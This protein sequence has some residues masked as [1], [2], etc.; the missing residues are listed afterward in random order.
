M[1]GLDIHRW[2]P[3]PPILV[4]LV[5]GKHRVLLTPVLDHLAQVAG[6]QQ[7]EVQPCNLCEGY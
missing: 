3:R 7:V 2:A 6:Q 5:A 1:G 4:L